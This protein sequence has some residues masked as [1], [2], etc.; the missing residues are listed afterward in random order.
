MEEDASRLHLCGLCSLIHIFL[1][2]SVLKLQYLVII[3][4]S[5]HLMD[6]I[7]L[8]YLLP[9]LLA[10]SI[11]HGCVFGLCIYLLLMFQLEYVYLGDAWKVLVDAAEAMVPNNDQ[12]TLISLT[13]FV[14]QLPSV[15]D[16]VA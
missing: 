5:V 14:D 10:L 7:I 9:I 3:G 4:Y 15:F 6:S 12:E 1:F 8:I 13:K 2:S 16:Q 11:V